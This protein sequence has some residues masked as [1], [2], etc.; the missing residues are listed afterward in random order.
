MLSAPARSALR[1]APCWPPA[2]GPSTPA[3]DTW[4]PPIHHDELYLAYLGKLGVKPQRYKKEIVGL[5]QDRK[6]PYVSMG[7][8]IEQAGGRPFPLEAQYSHYLVRRAI[9]KLDAALAG[10]DGTHP[11]YLQLDIF[12][13]H[14]PFTIPDGFEQQMLGTV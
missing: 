4:A 7:G 11:I 13:P 6:T 1:R 3:R 5:Q 10:N 9:E 12:D 14:Q 2:I 8:W